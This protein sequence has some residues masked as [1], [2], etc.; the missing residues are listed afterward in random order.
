MKFMIKLDAHLLWKIGI[1]LPKK[2]QTF[3][4]RE[5][6]TCHL[7]TLDICFN[8]SSF[9]RSNHESRHMDGTGDESGLCQEI[10]LANVILPI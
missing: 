6:T 4:C 3:H 8:A 5:I 10:G 1:L 9:N 2:H 7:S